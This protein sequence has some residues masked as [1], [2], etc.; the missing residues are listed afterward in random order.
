[1]NHTYA[2]DMFATPEPE[3]E[4]DVTSCSVCGAQL[5]DGPILDAVE[6]SLCDTCQSKKCQECGKYGPTLVDPAEARFCNEVC[7]SDFWSKVSEEERQRYVPTVIHDLVPEFEPREQQIDC[8]T[9][10]DE[11]LWGPNA[12]DVVL[13]QA[14]TGVGKSIIAL[15][16]ARRAR[17]AYL[18][19][20]QR[21]LQDQLGEH[22][23]VKKMKGRASY[24]CALTPGITAE[25]A[26]CTIDP[27][28]RQNNSACSDERCPYYKALAHAKSN[29][30]VV[31]NYASLMA[32]ARLGE[33][34]GRRNLLILDEGHTAIDWV[35][36]FIGFEVTDRELRSY[37]SIRPPDDD[38]DFM[39]WFRAILAGVEQAPAR[40]S[41]N[42][43]GVINMAI[44]YGEVFGL[45]SLEQVEEWKDELREEGRTSRGWTVNF[46]MKQLRD[47]GTIP[48]G[49]ESTEYDGVRT[50]T[51]TPLK[52]APFADMLT[53]LGEKLVIMSATI[54]DPELALME[55]GLSKKPYKYINIESAFDPDIRPVVISPIGSMGYK[56]RH[57]NTPKMIKGVQRVMALHPDERG[58]IHTYSYA[59]AESL[60]RGGLDRSSRTLLLTRGSDRDEKIKGFLAGDYGHN[61]VLI[62]PGLMEGVDGAYDSCRWQVIAKAPWPAMKDPVVDFLL[63]RMPA[64]F[65]PRAR[66]WYDWK[67]AQAF[68]Q[69]IGRVC[70]SPDD[71]G[72]TYILD[73]SCERIMKSKVIPRYVKL[74]FTRRRV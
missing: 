38:A 29:K 59:L 27:E 57:Q 5:H 56:Y 18:V 42:L 44:K 40:A 12:V 33:H 48:W 46:M 9:Q 2:D 43:T 68:V 70:R 60:Y 19:T 23:G 65:K 14:P 37:T 24:P 55:L 62:G 32:Q 3:P 66:A 52:A 7:Q 39:P 73:A 61:A 51:C 74:A 21:V 26:V 50:W 69:C 13:I 25:D 6:T 49:V 67:A 20:P 4:P 53:D 1:M 71:Y 36:N 11:A 41:K 31:H 64:W 45:P 17:N 54:L 8:Y 22:K 10:L 16:A 35:R 72:T 30:V 63:N 34:F 58:I 28:V 47:S 15:A